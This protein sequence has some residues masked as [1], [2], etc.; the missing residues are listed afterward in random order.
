METIGAQLLRFTVDLAIKQRLAGSRSTAVKTLSESRSY[1]PRLIAAVC[2]DSNESKPKRR[3]TR[4]ISVT[5]LAVGM[6]V[7][8]DIKRSDG[9]LVL[10]DGQHLTEL[11]V[12]TLNNYYDRRMIGRFVKI[13]VA[14][15][16]SIPVPEAPT[17]HVTAR[18]HSQRTGHSCFSGQP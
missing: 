2:P 18:A 17:C 15:E 9:T 1:D 7:A 11:S 5:D 10:S 8:G 12:V 16:P 13:L 14:A 4:D 3:V 6:E